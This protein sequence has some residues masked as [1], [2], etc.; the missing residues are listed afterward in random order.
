M[1]TPFRIPTLLPTN[2]AAWS[3]VTLLLF[4]L[5]WLPPFD[6]LD[7]SR[8]L[9]D[10]GRGG[11]AVEGIRVVV[12][13]SLALLGVACVV[14]WGIQG[15][16]CV[17][18]RRWVYPRLERRYGA[19]VALG[20]IVSPR[21][22]WAG[23][24]FRR[25][26]F[27]SA[28]SLVVLLSLCAFF[29][30]WHPRDLEA[31]RGMAAECHPVWRAFAFRQFARGDSTTALFAKYPPTRREEFGRYGVYHYGGPGFTGFYVVTRDGR[32]LTAGAGSCTWTFTFFETT[33]RQLDRD[34]E[35]YMEER[36]EGIRQ[37]RKPQPKQ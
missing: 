11:S 12:P 20:Y 24:W 25:A 1:R 13:I 6:F 15:V 23:R 21:R 30:V 16:G 26:V 14:A 8:E 19:G 4:S 5:L 36:L 22:L 10:S 18:F 33:D 7:L 35:A 27:A 34:Y 2:R 32:L 28:A 9:F 37:A 17:A 31:Y 3:V 29:R